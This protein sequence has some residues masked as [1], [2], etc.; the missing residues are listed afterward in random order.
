MKNLISLAAPM[1]V[2][3]HMAI[4]ECDDYELAI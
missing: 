3:F 1:K 4:D 2:C